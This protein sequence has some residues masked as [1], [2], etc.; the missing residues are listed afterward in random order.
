MAAVVVVPAGLPFLAGIREADENYLV[1][2]PVAQLR[3][4]AHHGPVL[5]WLACAM[6]CHSMLR[7]SQIAMVVNSAPLLLTLVCGSAMLSKTAAPSYMEHACL[8]STCRR[9]GARTPNRSHRPRRRFGTA[10][11]NRRRRLHSSTVAIP[12]HFSLRQRCSAPR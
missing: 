5:I 9:S 3:V 11:R 12:A 7:S 1:Q 2:E 6:Y 8:R 10:A 4:V